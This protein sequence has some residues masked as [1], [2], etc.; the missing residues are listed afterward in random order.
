MEEL[1]EHEEA[2]LG[3]LRATDTGALMFNGVYAWLY[4]TEIAGAI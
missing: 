1:P 4:S 3:R 2:A